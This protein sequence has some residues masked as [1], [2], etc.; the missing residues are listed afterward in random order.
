MDYFKQFL[1]TKI[2]YSKT[3]KIEFN[4]D[5]TIKDLIKY[6]KEKD[7]ADARDREKEK[8]IANKRYK[9][10]NLLVVI[11]IIV[12]FVILLIEKCTTT[13]TKSNSQVETPV[14]K[15]YKPTVR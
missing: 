12:P 7:E 4:E 13:P 6:T 1:G 5:S 8:A 11:S 9:Y 3:P 10:T 2:D 14:L 15:Q